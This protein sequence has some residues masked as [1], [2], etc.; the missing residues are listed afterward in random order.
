MSLSSI[1]DGNFSYLLFV[2]AAISLQPRLYDIE[3][4]TSF[5]PPKEEEN[6]VVVGISDPSKPDEKSG[7][8][9]SSLFKKKSAKR[10]RDDRPK[11]E[12]SIDVDFFN[13][14]SKNEA[15][16]K[17]VVTP[18]EPKDKL[19]EASEKTSSLIKSDIS[20]PK[21][22]TVTFE[23][24]IIPMAPVVSSVSDVPVLVKS[25]DPASKKISSKRCP[26]PDSNRS[27][28]RISSFQFKQ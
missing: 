1:W 12:D 11:E 18:P 5:L 16:A 22:E 17:S 6:G 21:P 3:V 24:K 23:V 25:K 10:P 27:S 13:Q 28:G 20:L 9:S 14:I 7:K 4:I 2:I 8:I 26:T 15:E 19:V